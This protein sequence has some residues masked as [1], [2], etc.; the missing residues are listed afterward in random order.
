[1]GPPLHQKPILSTTVAAERS[2]G[3]LIGA[4]CSG[5][6]M[7]VGVEGENGS[8]VNGMCQVCSKLRPNIEQLYFLQTGLV[9]CL[10]LFFQS[11]M[12]NSC[13]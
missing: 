9:F 2:I 13:R 6:Y 11:A 7:D 8:Q 5:C 1:M 12:S 3:H 10:L 4:M